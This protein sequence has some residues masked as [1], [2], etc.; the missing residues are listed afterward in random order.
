MGCGLA[1]T[2]YLAVEAAHGVTGAQHQRLLL[3]AAINGILAIACL[4][5]LVARLWI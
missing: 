3:A 5:L 2:T 4:A 1:A